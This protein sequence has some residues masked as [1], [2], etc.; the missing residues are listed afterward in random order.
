MNL[1]KE[2]FETGESN[3]N[4]VKSKYALLVLHKI[5]MITL[6]SLKHQSMDH[7]VETYP[8]SKLVVY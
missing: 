5:K 1:K 7:I 8:K 4:M 2:I 3:K 6:F